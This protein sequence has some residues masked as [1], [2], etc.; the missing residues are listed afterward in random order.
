MSGVAQHDDPV[1]STVCF[2]G[3][4]GPYLAGTAGRFPSRQPEANGGSRGLPVVHVSGSK[5]WYDRSR[6]PRL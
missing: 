4:D 3:D 1:C 2:K 6:Y 5:G